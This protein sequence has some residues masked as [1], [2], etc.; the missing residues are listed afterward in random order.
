[1]A[2]VPYYGIAE[3]IQ[4]VLQNE[5]GMEGVLVTVE[6]DG[7]MSTEQMPWVGIYVVDRVDDGGPI[8]GGTMQR[9]RVRYQIWCAEHAMESVK[10]ALRL[11]TDL[12]SRV[13][14]ALVKNPTANLNVASLRIQRGTFDRAQGEGGFIMA[15]S[16]DLEVICTAS[17]V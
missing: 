10:D 1:M 16:I 14:L 3:A 9:F 15:G 8:S 13:E 7:P 5:P 12:M 11:V 6:E 4:T 2:R 17:S